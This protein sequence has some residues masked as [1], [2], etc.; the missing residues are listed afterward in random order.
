MVQEENGS[1]GSQKITKISAL[2]GD[3]CY[4]ALLANS[5]NMAQ[6]RTISLGG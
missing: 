2:G 1:Q 3:F 6:D 5:V 4:I